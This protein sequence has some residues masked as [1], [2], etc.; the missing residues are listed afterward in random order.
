MSSFL[1]VESGS[2]KTDWVLISGKKKP[3]FYKSDGI[4]PYLQTAEHI[5]KQLKEQCDNIPKEVNHIYY[6][7]AGVGSKSNQKIVL[8]AL[9]SIFSCDDIQVEGDLLAAARALCQDQKGM[10]CI[11]GTGSNACFF[12]GIKIKSQLPSLGY[13]AGDEGSGNY[14]GKKVLQHYA[15][16][17][18]D[19]E[20]KNYFENE[21]GSDI[22]SIITDIYNHDFPNR[23]LAKFV[24]LLVNNR[25]HFMVENIIEDSIID[26]F[27]Q[28]L[29]RYRQTWKYPIHFT[30]SIA[31]LFSDVIEI[32][33]HQCN[34]E[35]GNIMQ[36][37][38]EGLINYHLKNK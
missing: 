12:D 3:I 25:N 21:F 1:I 15:Y 16:N 34:I 9:N 32:L 5:I 37:P 20:L 30:G 10:V 29:F 8:N 38:M 22:N 24:S 17:T 4:N 18:F 36:N 28:H 31:Y 13:I 33:S 35:L 11:L 26:F 27:R 6:Y 19:E 14:M 23:Y 7:G 2:T